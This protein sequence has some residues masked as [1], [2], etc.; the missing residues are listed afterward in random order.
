MKI[1]KMPSSPYI[2]IPSENPPIGS[3]LDYTHKHSDALEGASGSGSI[4]AVFNAKKV[5]VGS[6]KAIGG[7]VH[8]DLT[9]E[10]VGFYKITFPDAKI[11]API[12]LSDGQAVWIINGSNETTASVITTITN[13]YGQ[14]IYKG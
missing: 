12:H 2:R 8:V 10:G 9:F 13:T 11:P 7:T 5:S 6:Y 4:Y 14:L 1:D 3:H